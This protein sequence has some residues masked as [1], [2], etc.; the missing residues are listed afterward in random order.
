[1]PVILI[2]AELGIQIDTPKQ[3]M[4]RSVYFHRRIRINYLGQLPKTLFT[5]EDIAKVIKVCGEK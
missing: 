5:N 1:M 2:K 4:N 3:L